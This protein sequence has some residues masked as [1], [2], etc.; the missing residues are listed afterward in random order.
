[1]AC[2]LLTMRRE[3]SHRRRRGIY[4]W[5]GTIAVLIALFI[6]GCASA[7]EPDE[8]GGWGVVETIG[9]GVD[10]VTL[11]KVGGSRYEMGYRYGY[12][13][14]DQIVESGEKLLSLAEA[15]DVTELQFNIA[16]SSL[17]NRRFFDTRAWSEEIRGVVDGCAAAGHP[18]VDTKLIKRLLAVPDMS[19]Y[20]CSLFVAWGDATDT[21]ETVQLR[22]L[23]WTLDTGVQDYPVVVC[24][25]PDDG[26]PHIV[27]G[28]AGVLG[29]TVGGIN[30]AGLGLSEIQ[31]HF[32]DEESLRGIPYPVLFREILY[33]DTDVESAV[34]RIAGSRRTNQYH[35]AIGGDSNDTA[36]GSEPGVLLF[37][38]RS[39]IDRHEGG[40]E[41][42]NHSIV[43]PDPFYRPLQ[44]VVYWNRHNG[45]ANRLLYEALD[46][47]YGSSDA[48]SGIDIARAVGVEETL[49]SIVY[50]N[51]E[52]ALW[53][54]YAEGDRPAH[55]GEYVRIGLR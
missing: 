21:G 28:F 42:T 3:K 40:A 35:Y 41:I 33:Y 53:V 43:S 54:A 12:L 11:L 31:G 17:W 5:I 46:E 26:N 4:R 45:G 6:S 2:L 22:N 39:R 52:H 23:D 47:R 27:V 9:A 29:A 32:G 19:E 51:N 36:A 49:V 37:T 13:L 30:D 50:E 16:V 18:E 24:Y 14:A 55:L 20:G 8:V 38:S 10:Q 34:E 1:M 7:P 44:H 48:R 25:Y 15:Y